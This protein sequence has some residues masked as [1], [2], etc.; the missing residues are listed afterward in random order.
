MVGIMA[1]RVELPQNVGQYL[2][3]YTVQHPKKRVI[4][5]FTAV[6]TLHFAYDNIST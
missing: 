4:F 2:P 1:L 3:G 5:N 6:R